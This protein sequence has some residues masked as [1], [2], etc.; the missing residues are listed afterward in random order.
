MQT[1]LLAVF[2]SVRSDCF[3][4]SF[5]DG[6]L[7]SKHDVFLSGMISC[8]LSF[9]CTVQFL[10]STAKGRCLWVQIHFQ[11]SFFSSRQGGRDG[12]L[13]LHFGEHFE[14]RA[15]HFLPAE[16]GWISGSFGIY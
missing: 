13:A 4:D 11:F 14:S 16:T 6:L 5:Q 10:L 8:W 9:T 3:H 7:A 1:V 15:G 2:H 12:R